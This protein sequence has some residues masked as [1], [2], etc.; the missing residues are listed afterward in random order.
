MKDKPDR[1][2]P[3]ALV[4]FC[5]TVVVILAS[6]TL[7]TICAWGWLQSSA[8]G[9]GES[10]ST[11]LRNIGFL[12]AGIIALVFAVWRSWTAERQVRTAQ[13]QAESGQ[14]Q[15]DTAQSS[16]RHERYQRAAEMLGSNLLATRLG[17]IYA[18]QR[19]ATEYPEEYH[20][21]IM[22]LLCAF[23]RNPPETYFREERR[24]TLR[25]DTG[26]RETPQELQSDVQTA[27]TAIARRSKKSRMLEAAQDF[28]LNLHNAFLVKARLPG[29]NLAGA[30]LSG[31]NL[32]DADCNDADFS[33]ANLT[34]ANL[35]RARCASTNLA[36]A[37]MLGLI[38][39]K[40][41]VQNADFSKTHFSPRDVSEA[42]LAYANFSHAT[43]SP[44]DLS[45]AVIDNVNLT[46]TRFRKAIRS[47][48]PID[49]SPRKPSEDIFVRLT[50]AQLDEAKAD[51]DNPPTFDEG[52][53]DIETGEPLV[54]R[55]GIPE[56]C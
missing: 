35:S 24:A 56:A 19:L 22:E 17:G 29:A 52:T 20:I 54:W 3:S 37:Q 46:G 39:T 13:R 38:L 50:Q 31:A 51:A 40:T 44:T 53:V 2:P 6:S 21:Q 8:T 23:V 34:S 48:I 25:Q 45:K 41:L 30:N 14:K 15:A 42:E 18:L 32:E 4:W 27:I 7:I 12:T 26:Q 49:G 43:I 36:G 1:L 55:G 47:T 10:N 33:N 28:R 9:L 11:T 16:L 5:L